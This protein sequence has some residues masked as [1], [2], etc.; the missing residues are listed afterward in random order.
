MPQVF[1]QPTAS[2]EAGDIGPSE[3][4]LASGIPAIGGEDPI[5]TLGFLNQRQAEYIQAELPFC[6]SNPDMA[7]P[8]LGSVL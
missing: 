5:A 1:V 3:I 4:R 7:P 6:M 8:Q 2:P